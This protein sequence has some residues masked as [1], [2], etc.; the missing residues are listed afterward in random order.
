MCLKPSRSASAGKA[1]LWP[2]ALCLAVLVSAL[3]V[4]AAGVP[5]LFAPLVAELTQRGVPRAQATRLLRDRRLRFEGRLLARLLATPEH[6]LDYAQFLSP[7]SLKRARRFL[8]THRR[9][10]Q[11]IQRQTGVPPTVVVAILA[12]ESRLGAYQGRWRVF[13]VLASQA[14]LDTAAGRRALARFWPA[15]RRREL[16]RPATRR[17]LARRAVW[18]REELAALVHLARRHRLSPYAYRG[19]AAG[20]LGMCQFV[21]SSVLKHA[22]DGDRDG[23]ID[24]AR[25]P[26][27]MAS[28]ARYLAAHGWR[29]GLSRAQQEQV[30]MSYNRSRPYVRTVLALARRLK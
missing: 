8:A 6:R 25:P 24:L 14:V 29:S 27:A 21:P 18:A 19:S 2:A 4:R 30:L 5:R 13:N 7:A 23:R 26:D 10:L 17:R 28:V 3:P 22:A 1:L 12:V 9:H 15:K 20:A 11:R 16:D